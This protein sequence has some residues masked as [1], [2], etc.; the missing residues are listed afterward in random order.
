MH[1]R[2]LRIGLVE[3][4]G[5]GKARTSSPGACF[6]LLLALERNGVSDRSDGLQQIGT[7]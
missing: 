1:L 7:V 5:I 2:N 4:E 3:S 6:H